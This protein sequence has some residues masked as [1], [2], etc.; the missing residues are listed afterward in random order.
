MSDTAWQVP[1]YLD[2]RD[3]LLFLDGVDLAGLAES[4]QT[5]LYVYSANRILETV[6]AMRRSFSQH[7]P[8]A[9]IYY[10]S[11]AL[12][13]IKV[14]RMIRAEG[15]GVEVNS[16]G[17]LFRAKLAGF[18]PDSIISN[19]VS[20]SVEELRAA[21]SPPIKAINVDSLFELTRIIQVARDLKARAN[22]A[23]QPH[24]LGGLQIRY[25]TNRA[26]YGTRLDTQCGKRRDGDGSTCAYWVS[27]RPHGALRAGG[28]PARR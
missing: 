3:G 5:P 21:L 2:S 20:K 16:A 24:R 19:G 26:A 4:R 6:R 7:H 1:G 13:A 22:I 17:E 8:A 18:A 25:S 15:L 10:A 27:D 14:L 9:R 23:R 11:K 28:E 12:S